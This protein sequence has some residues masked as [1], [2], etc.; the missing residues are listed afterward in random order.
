MDSLPCTAETHAWA[1]IGGR[2]IIADPE[3]QVH[4]IGVFGAAAHEAVVHA[5]VHIAGPL[6]DVASHVIETER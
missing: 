2:G 4:V 3:S 6:P 5:F 1:E